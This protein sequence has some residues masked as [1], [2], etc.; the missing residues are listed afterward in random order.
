MMQTRS[1]SMSVEY[2]VKKTGFSDHHPAPPPA[3]AQAQETQAQAQLPEQ[4]AAV[5]PANRMVQ[6]V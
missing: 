4:A 5:A 2:V 1:V 3:Q 6:T